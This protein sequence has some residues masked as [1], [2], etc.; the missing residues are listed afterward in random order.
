MA[1]D[2]VHPPVTYFVTDTEFDGPDPAKNSL[3]SFASYAVRADAGVLDPFSTDLAP[4]PDR[5]PDPDTT[6]WWRGQPAAYQRATDHPVDPKEA[7]ARYAAWLETFA[8]VRVFAAQPLLIDG[9]WIDRYLKDFLGLSLIAWPSQER[10]LFHGGGLD[11]STAIEA[12][13]G[14]P[15]GRG[16]RLTDYPAD[17][18]QGPEDAPHTAANDALISARLLLRALRVSR[19]QPRKPDDFRGLNP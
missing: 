7:M 9:P 10:V 11:I 19:A 4:R 17:W 15:Y 18:T 13:Y 12:L 6:Q 5:A 14:W 2:P 8:G 3:L 1:Y 16:Y